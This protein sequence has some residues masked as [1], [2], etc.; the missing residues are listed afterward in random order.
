MDE[1]TSDTALPEQLSVY[2]EAI[3]MATAADLFTGSIR[4]V[5]CN[6]STGGA[7]PFRSPGAGV[8]FALRGPGANVEGLGALD[9]DPPEC[10]FTIAISDLNHF[11]AYARPLLTKLVE[12]AEERGCERLW[13][14]IDCCGNNPY[15]VFA[16]AGLDLISS[17]QVGGAAEVVL[18]LGQELRATQAPGG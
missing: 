11:H 12:A 15:E 18:Q 6:G 14:L 16:A 8:A 10:R 4:H 1:T 17:L 9:G 13:T 3:P 2:V 7:R 5:I